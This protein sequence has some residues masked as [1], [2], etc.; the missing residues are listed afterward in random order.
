MYIKSL[1]LSNVRNH[2]E[3]TAKFSPGLNIIH[4]L[5]GV[6]KT[7]MLEAISL[8]SLSKSFLPVPD[9]ALINKFK[10]FL[11]VRCDAENSLGVDYFVKVQYPKGQKKTFGNSYGDNQLPKNIIGEMPVVI[12]SPDYKTLTF[13]APDDRRQFLN[14][15]LSQSSKKYIDSVLKNKKYL[16]QRNKILADKKQNKKIDMNL[17]QIL[18]DMFIESSAE[19]II[20]REA[21]IAQFEVFFKKVYGEITDNKET[22]GLKYAPYGLA[23]IDLNKEAIAEKYKADFIDNLEDEFRRGTTI[24]GPQKDDMKIFIN[25]GISKQYASQGQHKSLLISLKFAEFFFLQDAK[26]ETPIILLDDIFSELDEQRSE[27]VLD[28]IRSN[29]AQTFIT[30]TNEEYISKFVEPSDSCYYFHVSEGEIKGME[31]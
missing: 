21:F 14:T 29:R 8:C 5:N 3:T 19:I 12:L 10:D 23:G 13:G 22:V 17:L 18:T 16:K 25:D 9:A 15:I 4:G 1:K 6:G 30:V 27:K 31:K 2:N 24:F 11:F 26:K 20:A 7:S 28:Y